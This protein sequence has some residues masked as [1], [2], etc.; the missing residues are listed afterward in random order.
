MARRAHCQTLIHVQHFSLHP[1]DAARLCPDPRHLFVLLAGPNGSQCR[2]TY[3]SNHC[4]PCDLNLPGRSLEH[5]AAR[6][7]ADG[8][9]AR[10]RGCG[11]CLAGRA[12]RAAALELASDL[13]TRRHCV[14]KQPHVAGHAGKLV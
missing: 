5:A 12:V 9:M 2:L 8:H 14:L 10:R 6:R 3:N 4:L 1:A 11:M 7:A 13:L